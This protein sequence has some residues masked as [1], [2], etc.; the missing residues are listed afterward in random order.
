MKQYRCSLLTLL[1]YIPQSRKK[2]ALNE[3]I[4][5]FRRILYLRLAGKCH[6]FRLRT[7]LYKLLLESNQRQHDK[8]YIYRIE[9][10]SH[11]IGTIK[12]LCD[13]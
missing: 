2:I 13:I 8:I 3:S 7:K 6:G 11:F 12:I 10:L 4:Q 5:R 9:P 1:N